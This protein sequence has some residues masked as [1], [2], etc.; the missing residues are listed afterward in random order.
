M[1]VTPTGV[2]E[3]DPAALAAL[4]AVRGPSV[5]AYCRHVAGEAD[6][7]AAACDAFARFRVAVVNAGDTTSLNPEA[8]LVSAT[9][10]SAAAC[11]ST[12]AQGECREVPALLAAR[13]D[14][15]IAADDLAR[16]E[17]HLQHC[18]ACRAP[19]TRFKAAERAYGD[20]PDKGVDPAL[21]AQIV[22]ALI[23]AVPPAPLPA[24]VAASANGRAAHEPVADAG[25]TAEVPLDQPTENFAAADLLERGP[26]D[27]GAGADGAD[28]AR[29]GRAKG[30]AGAPALLARLLP[31]PKRRGP[32]E[33]PRVQ[34]PRIVRGSP[35]PATP[36]ERAEPSRRRLRLAFVLPIALILCALIA[37]LH[38]AGV[39]GGSD[40]ASTPGVA[41]PTA[42]P[43]DP[44]DF[45]LVVV[46]GAEDASGDAVEKAKERARGDDDS[47]AANEDAPKKEDVDEA[48]ASAAGAPAPAAAAPPPPAPVADTNETAETRARERK[49]KPSE[50]RQADGGAATG[51]EQTPPP[52]DGSAGGGLSPPPEPATTP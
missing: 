11:A 52:A 48:P 41:V 1:T 50:E 51:A 24:P 40:P 7:A 18:W 17:A 26:A 32:R 6:A 49:T 19:V 30:P 14:K 5:V 20:P 45:E 22:G 27:A 9:R 4:C 33:R 35:A 10:T 36:R 2:R 46:P 43:V 12:V 16:L 47:G 28:G 34:E 29:P 15:A 23:A 44:P 13:A 39:L 38:V 31:S 3:G 25:A 8:L 42:E 37:A 21:A